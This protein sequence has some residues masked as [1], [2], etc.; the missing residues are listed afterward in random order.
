MRCVV[1]LDCGAILPGI[2]DSKFVC[3]TDSANML[4]HFA[5]Y[6]PIRHMI[7]AVY[8]HDLSAPDFEMIVDAALFLLAARVVK[9]SEFPQASNVKHYGSLALERGLLR[10]DR[11]DY[12]QRFAMA[13]HLHTEAKRIFDQANNIRSRLRADA[14]R[15]MNSHD[16]LSLL[17]GT[18]KRRRYVGAGATQTE[19]Y[20]VY[21][22]TITIDRLQ[23]VPLVNSLCV[24][25]GV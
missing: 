17:Y 5:E 3:F 14:R 12:I 9:Y 16:F 6:E 8:G 1:D 18:L 21:Q 13:N 19:F 10:F 23:A 2:K 7:G 11:K 24:W 4:I 15:Y 20:R 25:A 22:A